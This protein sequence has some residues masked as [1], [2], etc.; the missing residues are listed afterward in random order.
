METGLFHADGRRDRQ[1]DRE[2][3]MIKLIV[4]LRNFT[5]TPKIRQKPSNVTAQQI[6][7]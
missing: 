7:S 2:T 3:D 5:N 4:T 1:I 6:K